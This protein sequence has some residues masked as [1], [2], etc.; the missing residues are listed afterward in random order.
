MGGEG[1]PHVAWF[2]Q[3]WTD[4]ARLLRAVQ[5]TQ[6][7]FTGQGICCSK[8]TRSSKQPTCHRND[9]LLMKPA[10]SVSLHWKSMQ[11]KLITLKT[12]RSKSGLIHDS[13]ML[14]QWTSTFTIFNELYIMNKSLNYSCIQLLYGAKN[15]FLIRYFCLVLQYE[16]K[17]RY[18]YLRSGMN[19]IK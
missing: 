19:K 5:H 14:Y 7:T 15:Y 9:V 2:T 1:G 6:V 11:S 12:C 16:F 17:S 13:N 8:P 3:Q 18:I 10:R 4:R